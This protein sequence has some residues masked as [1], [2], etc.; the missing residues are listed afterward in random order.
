MITNYD[1]LTPTK[2]VKRWQKKKVDKRSGTIEAGKY[3]TFKQPALFDTYNKYMGGVDLH[4]N[5]VQN[6]RVSIRSKKWYDPLWKACLDSAVV[7][8]WKLHCF[9]Q[10]HQNNKPMPQKDFRVEVTTAL[11]LFS[12]HKR[13]EG[14]EEEYQYCNLPKIGADHIVIKPE[15]QKRRRCKFCHNHTVYMCQ[16]CNAYVHPKCFDQYHSK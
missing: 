8:A 13:D 14:G 4:D 11:L 2:N 6:Y 15:D 12:E 3:Q 16:K 5:G 10:Q 9:V 1:T 7:N